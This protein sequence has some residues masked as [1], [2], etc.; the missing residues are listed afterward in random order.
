M[1]APRPNAWIDDIT[2][3]VPGKASAP[4]GKPLIKLS[5]NENPF[6]PPPSA[7]DAM[8]AAEATA[9]R[10]PEGSSAKL[11]AAIAQRYDLD[12]TRVLCGAG[13]DEL[14]QLIA[15]A[16]LAP[17]DECLMPQY[18]FSVYPIAAR[19]VGGVPVEAPARDYGADVDALLAA[20]TP[21]TRVLMIANP[22]NPTGTLLKRAEV[23]RLHAGLRPDILLVLDG[24][25]AEY[26]DPQADNYEDGLALSRSAPNVVT[27]RTFSKIHGLGGARVGWCHGSAHVIE[28]L[29]K[30]R[31]PFNVT[32]AAQAGAEA[33]LADVDFQRRSYEHNRRW[34]RWLEGELAGLSNHGIRVIPSAANFVMLSFPE[35]GPVAAEAAYKALMADGYITRWLVPQGM[36]RELRVSV[37]TEDETRGVAAALRRFVE[38]VA[39]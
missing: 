9:H 37:G 4:D 35:D 36:A 18:A 31:G 25:Y 17:G 2:A 22:N 6:G 24:A 12:P 7:V 1:N 34:L 28:A 16:F 15:T 8:R 33:A 13:S 14:L 23:L 10:Y 39:G 3:Y 30:I 21:R 20:V 19:R 32:S 5:S 29:D 38:S 26:L 11:R 27:T